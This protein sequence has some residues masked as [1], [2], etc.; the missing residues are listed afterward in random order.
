ML[1]NKILES[2]PYASRTIRQ[3]S[4]G[5]LNADLTFQQFRILQLTY[6]GMGQTQMAQTLHVSMAAISKVVEALVHKNLLMREQCEDRRCH[7]LTLTREGVKVRKAIHD[8]VARKLEKNFKK[9]STA[10]QRDLKKGLEVLDKLMGFV[11]E[12]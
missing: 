1:S 8:Q 4:A 2:I 3:L 11:N 9:L 7:K 5:S 10:E 12:K 6:D